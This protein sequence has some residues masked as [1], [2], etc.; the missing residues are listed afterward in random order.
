[1]REESLNSPSINEIAALF[2]ESRRLLPDTDLPYGCAQIFCCNTSTK[3]FSTK[4]D[5]SSAIFSERELHIFLKEFESSF[6]YITGASLQDFITL[7][8]GT[9]SIDPGIYIVVIS[10]HESEAEFYNV[11]GSIEVCFGGG[12]LGKHLQSYE[13]ENWAIYTQNNEIDYYSDVFWNGNYGYIDPQKSIDSMRELLKLNT[14]DK[15]L[16]IFTEDTGS[17]KNKIADEI[18]S[19]YSA[20]E[21]LLDK[22]TKPSEVKSLLLSSN[23]TLSGKII[24]RDKLFGK[25]NYFYYGEIKRIRNILTHDSSVSL[26]EIQLR[27]F[28][29]LLRSIYSDLFLNHINVKRGPVQTTDFIKNN[30]SALQ[31]GAVFLSLDFLHDCEK[32]YDIII[33]SEDEFK[34]IVLN[35]LNQGQNKIMIESEVE[36]KV[37]N[38]NPQSQ[39]TNLKDHKNL[40]SCSKAGLEAVTS[41]ITNKYVPKL[42]YK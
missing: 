33:K 30:S 29:E 24:T 5:L 18:K 41:W 23:N 31:Q 9:G 16:N 19:S 40:C 13:I 22:K 36:S 8:S 34:S 6:P 35:N 10:W 28:L 26:N 17:Q 42:M 15:S 11:K 12:F 37:I 7:K 32:E 3:N 20:L 39:C 1:M 4:K 21:V 25:E 27:V 2:K 14:I 38:M